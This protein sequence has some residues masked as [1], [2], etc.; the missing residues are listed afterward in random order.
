MF[1]SNFGRQEFELIVDLN[2]RHASL[3]AHI[4]WSIFSGKFQT[5]NQFNKLKM[6]SLGRLTTNI[7]N[8]TYIYPAR[9]LSQHKIPS[10]RSVTTKNISNDQ[11]DSQDDA[12][13]KYTGSPAYKWT[14]KSSRTG[15]TLARLW[16]EPYVI[17]GSLFVFLV[18][19]CVLREENHIDKELERTLY[20]RI[21][22]L[23]EYQLHASLEHNKSLGLSTVELEARLSEL[24]KDK[25]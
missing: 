20:S 6:N 19:F 13:I 15:V 16:Y 25:K 3:T 23:E 14:A 7:I 10:S 22:G 24:A 4:T 2:S 12:P 21:S 9:L 5:V 8:K 11:D 17:L 1:S 18:Y